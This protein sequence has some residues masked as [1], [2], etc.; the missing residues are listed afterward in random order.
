MV[1]AGCYSQLLVVWDIY[2]SGT[3]GWLLALKI[4]WGGISRDQGVFISLSLKPGYW[5]CE[6]TLNTRFEG[7]GS[8]IYNVK[9]D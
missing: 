7:F 5:P 2:L 1:S 9:L 8:H 4:I 3:V 6:T